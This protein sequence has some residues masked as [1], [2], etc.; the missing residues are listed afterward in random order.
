MRRYQIAEVYAW[1]G[2]KDQAIE[3]LEYACSQHDP[4]A[5]SEDEFAAVRFC[6]KEPVRRATPTG[7]V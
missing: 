6:K 3:W 7:P 2:E 5:A 4:G 1:R